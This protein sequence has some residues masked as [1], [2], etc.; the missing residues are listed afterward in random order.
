MTFDLVTAG[1]RRDTPT[2]EMPSKP[3]GMLISEM[4]RCF[5]A[6]NHTPPAS[7][8]RAAHAELR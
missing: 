7:G 6:I 4:V 5:C 8:L 2:A 1:D 3:A